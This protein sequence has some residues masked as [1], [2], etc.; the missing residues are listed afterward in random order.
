MNTWA[1]LIGVVLGV[2]WGISVGIP[3]G[4]EKE[5]KAHPQMDVCGQ[6]WTTTNGLPTLITVKGGQKCEFIRD[7]NNRI[8]AVVMWEK[9]EVSP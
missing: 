8:T 3:Y 2:I 5:R 7:A 6:T 1:Y 4:Q 9:P